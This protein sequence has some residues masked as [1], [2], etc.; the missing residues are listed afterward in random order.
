[1]LEFFRLRTRQHPD[2]GL[3]FL[4]RNSCEMWQC[5]VVFKTIK[6]APLQMASRL[7]SLVHLIF[8]LNHVSEIQTNLTLYCVQNKI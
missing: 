2:P 6:A 3:T 8:L 5:N 4:S 1:M 7:L